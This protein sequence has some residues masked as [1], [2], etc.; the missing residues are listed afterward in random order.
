MCNPLFRQKIHLGYVDSRAGAAGS[1]VDA[2]AQDEIFYFLK[3]LN[4]LLQ[5]SIESMLQLSE[6]IPGIY[7]TMQNSH[8][9]ICLSNHGFVVL[10]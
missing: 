2:Y 9:V 1:P 5:T 4:L 3:S 7:V 8:Y 6:L 10:E